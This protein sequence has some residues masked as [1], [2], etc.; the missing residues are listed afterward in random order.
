MNTL[1]AKKNTSAKYHFRPV[2]YFCIGP[3]KIFAYYLDMIKDIILVSQMVILI[4]GIE[5]IYT[6]PT[7]FTSI[8]S[9][10]V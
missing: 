8:V 9:E 5:F 2:V 6:N 3:M 7:N 10:T 1:I 4:G